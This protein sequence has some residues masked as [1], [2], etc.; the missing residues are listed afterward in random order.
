MKLF[1]RLDNLFITLWVQI[2]DSYL[3]LFRHAIIVNGYVDDHTWRGIRHRNW[4][5]DLNYYFLQEITGRPVVFY[6]NFKLAQWLHFKNYVCIGTLIDAKNC[7][8]AESVIWGAGVSGLE[9]SFVHPVKVLA[10][11][12]PLTKDYCERYG[13]ACPNIFGDP[14]LLLSLI[15]NPS[16]N[17]L[18]KKKIGLIPNVADMEHPVIKE[19]V[20]SNNSDFELIDLSSYSEWTE[21]INK[22]AMCRCV[23]SSSL[24]GIIVSDVYQVHNC[25]IKLSGKAI[26]GHLKFKDYLA[27]VGRDERSAL[28]IESIQD[29]YE[30]SNTENYFSMADKEIIEC[31]QKD[32][33]RVSPLRL[34]TVGLSISSSKF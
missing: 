17:R 14:A 22:I 11:R 26:V 19:L 1:K 16:N 2:R 30:F 15:Y 24:H 21:V 32:L 25:W 34:K 9:R 13:V 31:L 18:P 4:G 7:V 20:E 8:T 3:Y 28:K 10:V 23:F 29:L 27:S 33:L 5:D 12:G 6:H